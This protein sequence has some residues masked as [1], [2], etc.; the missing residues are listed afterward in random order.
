VRT[1]RTTVAMVGVALAALLVGTL[2][3]VAQESEEFVQPG[4]EIPL[5]GYTRT[6][7]TIVLSDEAFCR[8]LLGGLWG[9][10]ELTYVDLIDKTKKQKKAR[11]AGFQAGSDEETVA[12]C[13]GI[14][15]A[16]RTDPPED[17]ALAAWARRAPVVP[18]ALAGLLPADLVARPLAQ[19]DEVGQA[20]RTAGFG[21]TVSAPFEMAAETWLAEV[22][23]SG[24]SEW[25][26]SLRNARDAA[27]AIELT[28]IRE[29]LYSVDPGH[30]YW[31]VSASACD[32]SVDLVPIE[33]G[34]VP[35]PTPAPR[36]VVPPLFSAE[37]DRGIGAENPDHLTAAQARE[38]VLEAGLVTG[39][40][41]ID[42][43]GA[44]K[45]DRVWQQDP[46]A[47]SLAG[48]GSAVDIW[49]GT[50]CDVYIGD[51]VIFE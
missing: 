50:D 31:E 41:T 2:T 12:R 30:Y 36:A 49:V 22:D 1:G 42:A 23:A 15:A 16:F 26:G 32:W 45:D 13:A 33:L 14:I 8:H 43:S 40:C 7:G 18:E 46:V 27:D 38:A 25:T 48:F 29:Y 37:W 3:V 10:D 6:D 24:C 11:R 39:A 34:P 21:D 51:R 4:S 20:A 5:D 28:G 19:P 44:R 35:T 9:S 47:G 17:D